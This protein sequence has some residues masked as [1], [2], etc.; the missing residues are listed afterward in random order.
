MLNTHYSSSGTQVVNLTRIYITKHQRD[1]VPL[2]EK[3]AKEWQETGSPIYRP[4]WWLNP[5]DPVTFTIDDQFL[6]GD[7]VTFHHNLVLCMY[8]DI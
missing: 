6:I 2:I 5:E 8:P 4:M 1:V 7:E 3:Y